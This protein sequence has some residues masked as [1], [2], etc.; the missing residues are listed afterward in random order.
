MKA[1]LITQGSA[2]LLDAI[3]RQLLQITAVFEQV[4]PGKI[5]FAGLVNLARVAGRV[6]SSDSLVARCRELEIQ[7]GVFFSSRSYSL[8]ARIARLKPDIIIV[9]SMS[10][11]LPRDIFCIPK[12]GSLNI[13]LS[14]LPEYRGPDPLFWQ[15]LNFE[16]SPGVTVHCIDEGEDSGRVLAQTR[17]D[18]EPGATPRA[19]ESTLLNIAGTKLLPLAVEKTLLREPQKLESRFSGGTDLIRARRVNRDERGVILDWG[20]SFTPE[21]A[22][23]FFHLPKHPELFIP[24]RPPFSSF[25]RWAPKSFGPL[26]PGEQR[27]VPPGSLVKEGKKFFLQVSGGYV[28]FDRRFRLGTAIGGLARR[29]MGL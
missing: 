29:V 20:A 6:F 3:P 7:Y 23:H 2:L 15:Y 9:Y 4:S 12:Y 17:I 19:L 13:H 14:F 26:G 5:S 16:L 8:T 22:F 28:E 25:F 27:N 11:L 24:N 21:R 1:V 18:I 10:S